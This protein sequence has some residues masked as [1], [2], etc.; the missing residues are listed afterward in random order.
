MKTKRT[1]SPEETRQIGSELARK[2]LRGPR[3]ETAV[4]MG[5]FANL[6]G[7]KTTLV[8]GFLKEL[9][10]RK[11]VTSPTFVIMRRY[12]IRKKYFR[13]AYHIDAYRLKT[14]DLKNLGFEEIRKNPANIILIE[15]P[16]NL[17]IR[18]KCKIKIRMEHGSRENERV[19]KLP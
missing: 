18:S 1:Y 3:C 8:Q 9:G 14:K 13:N 6:G 15:W 19:I 12:P 4:I 10:W 2:V 7:G 5:L 11:R 16:E 17:A